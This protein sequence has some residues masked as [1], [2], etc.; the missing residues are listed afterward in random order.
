MENDNEVEGTPEVEI[1]SKS[2]AGVE[3]DEQSDQKIKADIQ[4]LQ[5]EEEEKARIKKEKRKERKSFF[6][7]LLTAFIIA[8][9]L[10]IFV[11]EFVGIDGPSMEPTLVKGESVVINKLVYKYSTP[12]RGDVVVVLF[13]D[14]TEH[15]VKRVIGLPGETIQI[16]NGVVYINGQAL[17]TDYYNKEE[18]PAGD[19][20]PIVVEQGSVFLM[21][22]NRNHSQDSRALG[23]LK[24]SDI[25]G[26][27][28]FIVWPFNRI[29]KL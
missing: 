12:S 6:L 8:L 20:G 3:I 4:K 5:S 29:K 22:D 1:N 25:T 2:V 27:V 15:Y 23:T 13:P 10:R 14:V 21:G 18:V 26:K 28:E 11:F 9:S 19:F 17:S 24:I 7:T 16:K